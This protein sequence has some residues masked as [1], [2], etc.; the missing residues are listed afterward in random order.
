MEIPKYENGTYDL[1]VL[2]RLVTD[3]P[4]IVYG[5]RHRHYCQLSGCS[6][7]DCDCPY[8]KWVRKQRSID[9]QLPDE[10]MIIEF[11]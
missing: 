9:R 3:V 2:A 11:H 1:D 4:D 6:G 7:N 8:C 10:I 5:V